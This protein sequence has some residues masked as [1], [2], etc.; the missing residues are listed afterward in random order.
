MEAEHIAASEA[1]REVVWLCSLLQEIYLPQSGPSKLL[2][3]NQAAG[4]LSQNPLSHEKS[5][6]IDI[7]YHVIREYREWTAVA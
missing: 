1:T 7:R 6:H 5:K 4:S 3:D 2:I